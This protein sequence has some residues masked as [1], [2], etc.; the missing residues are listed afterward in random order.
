LYHTYDQSPEGSLSDRIRFTQNTNL[1]HIIKT[2]ALGVQPLVRLGNAQKLTDGI[3]A[4][5]FEALIGAIYLDPSQGLAKV[6]QLVN[7][8]LSKDIRAFDIT[9]DYISSLQKYVQQTLREFLDKPEYI[10]ISDHVDSQ[11]RHAFVYEVRL[12]SQTIGRG[13]GNTSIVAKQL[14]AKSALH[15]LTSS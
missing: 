7:G 5:I 9:E 2:K 4:D 10:Q 6:K 8:P 14:A 1:A 12:K 15:K 11:N 3:L 13:M